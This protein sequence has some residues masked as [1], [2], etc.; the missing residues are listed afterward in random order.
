MKYLK[1]IDMV[2]LVKNKS[3]WELLSR[4]DKR[5]LTSGKKQYHPSNLLFGSILLDRKKIKIAK[6]RLKC[7]DAEI[8]QYISENVSILTYNNL[9][10]YIH[11]TDIYNF[12]YKKF[13]YM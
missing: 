12:L 6:K 4:G 3:A 2:E 10:M 13:L 8:K 7:K 1:Y 9:L 5:L 11:P